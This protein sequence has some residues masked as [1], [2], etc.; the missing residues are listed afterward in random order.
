ML[1]FYG[2][3]HSHANR[4]R[5]EEWLKT[6]SVTPQVK[7]QMVNDWQIRGFLTEGDASDLIRKGK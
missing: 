6:A 5:I 7:V 1:L 4:L 2:A 3:K